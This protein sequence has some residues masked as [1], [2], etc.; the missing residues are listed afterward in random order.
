MILNLM[1]DHVQYYTW[2]MNNIYLYLGQRIVDEI[3]I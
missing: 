1:N 2:I 3:D